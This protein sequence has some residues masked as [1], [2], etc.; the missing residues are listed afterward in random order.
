MADTIVS[1][2]QMFF[3]AASG[4]YGATLTC[5]HHIHAIPAY[6]IVTPIHII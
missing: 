4:S 6:K 3:I 2:L 1:Q 5:A